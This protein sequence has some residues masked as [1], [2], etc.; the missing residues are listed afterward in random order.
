MPKSHN[1]TKKKCMRVKCG[2][3]KDGWRPVYCVGKKSFSKN[4]CHC[5]LSKHL[6]CKSKSKLDIIIYGI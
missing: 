2:D 6:K 5:N 3:C 4:W 1:M